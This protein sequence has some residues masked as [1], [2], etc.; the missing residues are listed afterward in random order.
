[1]FSHHSC[2]NTDQDVDAHH[3]QPQLRKHRDQRRGWL[4]LCIFPLQSCLAGS[5]LL[6]LPINRMLSYTRALRDSLMEQLTNIKAQ[7]HHFEHVVDIV[8]DKVVLRH[9]FLVIDFSYGYE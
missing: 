4:P 9:G 2:T 6:I 8:A 7:L 1:M 3:L 5:S